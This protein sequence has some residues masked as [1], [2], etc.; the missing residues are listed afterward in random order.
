MS[1]LYNFICTQNRRTNSAHTPMLAP[2]KEAVWSILK[3]PMTKDLTSHILS[4]PFTLVQ[5]VCGV[6]TAFAA[7]GRHVAAL[8]ERRILVFEYV[9]GAVAVPLQ[10]VLHTRAVRVAA[11]DALYWRSWALHKL[12][13]RQ[14]H[15]HR[16][17]IGIIHNY[18]LLY[19]LFVLVNM[20]NLV[21]LAC[22]FIF[23]DFFQ[24]SSF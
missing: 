19:F 5:L 13:L 3:Q 12:R 23:Q 4:S 6:R 18:V 1:R 10:S 24:S 9:P 22:T 8:F 11:E 16:C 2:E 17:N 7:L 21:N 15:R 20:E 14:F